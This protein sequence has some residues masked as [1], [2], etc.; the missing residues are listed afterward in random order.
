MRPFAFSDSY[1][2]RTLIKHEYTIRELGTAQIP[3]AKSISDVNAKGQY[4]E[5]H[6]LTVMRLVVSAEG[7]K[8]STKI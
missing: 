5:T 3:I 8:P 2:Y 1:A 6:H 4:H 7:V